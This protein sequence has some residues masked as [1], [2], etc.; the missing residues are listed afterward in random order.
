[1]AINLRKPI[2]DF[3]KSRP[4]IQKRHPQI[5]TTESRPRH[6][7]YSTVSDEAEVA[8]GEGAVV[9]PGQTS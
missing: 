4:D 2:I 8:R 5:K 9:T 6:Y 1:M 3:L 7:F